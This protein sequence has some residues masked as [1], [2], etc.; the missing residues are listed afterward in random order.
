MTLDSR[1]RICDKRIQTQSHFDQIADSVTIRIPVSHICA[2]AVLFKICQAIAV[3]VTQGVRRIM[4]IQPVSNLN[5]IRDSISVG[6]EGGRSDVKGDD[7]L[8]SLVS[9]LD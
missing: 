8:S 2:E 4:R 3:Q 6:I 7:C 9:R 5:Y 1:G